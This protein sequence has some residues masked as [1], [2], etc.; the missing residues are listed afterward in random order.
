VLLGEH[1][2][3]EFADSLI[4][5]RNIIN[6]PT[7]LQHKIDALSRDLFGRETEKAIA[8]RSVL[9]NEDHHPTLANLVKTFFDV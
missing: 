6:A 1:W 3:A 2:D 8:I 7:V 5:Q 9:V 4:D